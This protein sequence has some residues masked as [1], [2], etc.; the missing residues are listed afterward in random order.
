MIIE[1]LPPERGIGRKPTRRTAAK[2]IRD[3]PARQVHPGFH[4]GVRTRIRVGGQPRRTRVAPASGVVRQ[5]H[6]LFPPGKASLEVYWNGG[7][8]SIANIAA[9]LRNFL[10]LLR[11][12][13][14]ESVGNGPIV[15][16]IRHVG[17]GGLNQP[18]ISVRLRRV[19]DPADITDAMGQ[20]R[21]PAPGVHSG[22]LV[23]PAEAEIIVDQERPVVVF[24]AEIDQVR[25]DNITVRSVREDVDLRAGNGP[26]LRDLVREAG[27]NPR[28]RGIR[29]RV[30]VAGVGAGVEGATK[31]LDVVVHGQVERKLRVEREAVVRLHVHAP[32]LAVVEILPRLIAPQVGGG[33]HRVLILVRHPISTHGVLTVE[34]VHRHAEI[35]LATQNAEHLL[36]TEREEGM[37][38][39]LLSQRDLLRERRGDAHRRAVRDPALLPQVER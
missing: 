10:R 1:I 38:A 21:R 3:L 24:T 19:D 33:R 26:H 34:K 4:I 13:L 6:G 35:A 23:V 7:R 25:F 9:G 37:R 8:E 22:L 20:R 29:D 17:A 28:G 12:R 30:G 32:L 27:H 16:R 5:I 14:G 15:G 31:P 11:G 36:V 39:V 2:E 18:R